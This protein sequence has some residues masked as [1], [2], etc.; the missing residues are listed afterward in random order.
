[1]KTIFVTTKN[2]K[3]F[4]LALQ[5]INH[6]HHG[7]ERIALVAGE[8]GLG[9]TVAGIYFGAR[10]G[11]TNLTIWP[12]MTQHWLLRALAKELGIEPAWRTEKLIEQIRNVLL[13]EPR[14]LIF[15][16]VD[17][18][19]RDNDAKK[20]DALETLRKIHDT[21]CCPMVLIGEERIDKK[22]ERI[23]RLSDRIIEIVRFERYK[24]NDVK[25]IIEQ[26]SDYRFETNAIEKITKMSDGRIRPI[27]RLIHAAEVAARIHQLKTIEGKDF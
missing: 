13:R 17:H 22:I 18:F 7:I 14:I 11:A 2:I 4:Q 5:R 26:L 19:F 21:C 6:K 9:K 20:I 8:V 24:E 12:R 3:R 16:E 27:I 15:D 10:D 1:M 23:P 25:N